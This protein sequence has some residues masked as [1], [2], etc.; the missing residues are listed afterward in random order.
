MMFISML[1]ANVFIV[2]TISKNGS[3]EKLHS[4]TGKSRETMHPETK[5]WLSDTYSSARCY[6]SKKCLYVSL[7]T[8]THT[9]PSLLPP[10]D[11]A[12]HST[13]QW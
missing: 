10:K 5:L 8:H 13:S 4:N 7:H 2:N 11:N 3:S 6:Q 1:T 12:A 9:H